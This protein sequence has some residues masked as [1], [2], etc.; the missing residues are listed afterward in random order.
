M[1][2]PRV[3]FILTPQCEILTLLFQERNQNGEAH[4][5]LSSNQLCILSLCIGNYKLGS[6]YCVRDDW[7]YLNSRESVCCFGTTHGC[8][9]LLYIVLF[10][11]C[12]VSQGISCFR[13]ACAGKM[14]LSLHTYWVYIR[15]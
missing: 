2:T 5:F 14:S 9:G 12:D 8:E 11:W 6:F 10:S 7:P 15:A 3:F 13:E 1:I 4:F